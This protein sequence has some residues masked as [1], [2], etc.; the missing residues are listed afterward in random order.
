MLS[1]FFMVG[2]WNRKAFAI[3]FISLLKVSTPISDMSKNL[4]DLEA[5]AIFAKIAETG[6]FAKTAAD[7]SLSQP[8]VSK[9]ITRLETR[10]KTILFHRSS[11]QMSL[12]ECG[13]AA[14]ER[15]TRILEEGR[16]IEAEI[17]EQATA[18]NG[19]IRMSAPM[20]F[21]LPRLSPMLPAFMQAHPGVELDIQF[22][23]EQVD[24]ITNRFDLAL[25]VSHMVD[26]SLLAR[27]LCT[28]RI[29][30]VGAPSY[31]ERYGRPKHPRDLAN[32]KALHYTYSRGG[33]SWHFKH[34][35]HGSFSQFVTSP[36]QANNADALVP[37]L[38]AGLGLAL[39]PE[40]LAWQG[41]QSGKL[42]TVMDDWQV[43][44][45]TLH[46]VS[47]PG[48]NRPARVKALIDYLVEQF[49]TQPWAQII[50]KE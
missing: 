41:L 10:M 19:V 18:L 35:R 46:L 36:L 34:T 2:N 13:Q 50:P 22:G 25:R 27:A 44:P 39:Q 20:S 17:T 48:R 47:P 32:H 1:F 40:F 29:L 24:L 30:L 16:A 14:L 21:G 7:L 38:H 33:R 42:Q 15:A 23:D 37:A 26:S 28:V 9:A 4:P 8:T 11:R 49:E 12:T 31:F 5:W 45:I 6:S 43:E 3:L